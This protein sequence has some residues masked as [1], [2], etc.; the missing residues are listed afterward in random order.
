MITDLDRGDVPSL[1]TS[2]IEKIV[3]LGGVTLLGQLADLY[4]EQLDERAAAVE[5][6]GKGMN[7]EEGTRAAHT[8]KSTSAQLGLA[9][10]GRLA[11][12]IESH[13]RAGNILGVA[14][15]LPAFRVAIEEGRAALVAEIACRQE[16]ADA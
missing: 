5:A 6:L 16:A 7:P 12:E 4:F 8:L 15:A 14:R 1:Q 2:M 10:L 3:A 11:G 9:S 13:G